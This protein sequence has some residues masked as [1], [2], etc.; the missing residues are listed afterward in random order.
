M[1]FFNPGDAPVS[2]SIRLLDPAGSRLAESVPLELASKSQTARFV[3]ELFSGQTGTLGSLASRAEDASSVTG[4]I[5]V[6]LVLGFVV[7][8][9]AIGSADT[10]WAQ[11]VSWLPPTA[12][13]AMPIRTAMGATSW[14]EPP[15]A[16]ALTVVAIAGL[17]VLGGRVYTRAILHTGTTMSLADAW[18][19][20]PVPEGPRRV[21]LGRQ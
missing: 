11:V 3:S 16:A 9:A 15:G 5:M 1:A 4:P 2:V 8:F 17:V 14:W 19:G 12:P 6:V 21:Q 20:G 7:S 13:L 18:R 10:A